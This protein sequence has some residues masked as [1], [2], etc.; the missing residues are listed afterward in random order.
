VRRTVFKTASIMDD[1]DA[2]AV[3]MESESERQGSVIGPRPM[4]SQKPVREGMTGERRG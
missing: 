4:C 3:S 1:D 2:Q